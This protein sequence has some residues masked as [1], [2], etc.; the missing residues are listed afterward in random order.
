VLIERE[1]EQDRDRFPDPQGH[2]RPRLESRPWRE[3]RPKRSSSGPTSALPASGSRDRDVARP[4]PRLGFFLR[5][6]SSKPSATT[7]SNINAPNLVRRLSGRD[8]A[9]RMSPAP[10]LVTT[11]MPQRQA[12][13]AEVTRVRVQPARIVAARAQGER[14]GVCPLPFW[15]RELASLPTLGGEAGLRPPPAVHATAEVVTCLCPGRP[16]SVTLSAQ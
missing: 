4:C 1:K 13:F 10:R 16:S 7:G 11:A 9:A 14:Q 3:S 6:T 2:R 15:R 5:S 8:R 12:L